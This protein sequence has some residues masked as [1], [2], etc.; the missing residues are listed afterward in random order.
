[1]PDAY[2]QISD[3]PTDTKSRHGMD[4]CGAG[5]RAAPAVEAARARRV[6]WEEKRAAR[7]AAAGKESAS[8]LEALH[9]NFTEELADVA[10]MDNELSLLLASI[11]GK[12]PPGGAGPPGGLAL[13]PPFTVKQIDDLTAATDGLKKGMMDVTTAGRDLATSMRKV[14]TSLPSPCA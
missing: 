14:H 9:A 2:L 6:A 3:P 13:A 8:S 11:Q 12:E 7:A 5:I 10:D 4:V 1:M